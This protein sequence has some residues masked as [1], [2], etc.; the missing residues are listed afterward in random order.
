MAP[1]AS[2]QEVSGPKAGDNHAV[3]RQQVFMIE[4]WYRD[5]STDE[6][7]RL[8]DA[9]EITRA[10]FPWTANVSRFE[11]YNDRIMLE[12]PADRYDNKFWQPEGHRDSERCICEVKLDTAFATDILFDEQ[13]LTNPNNSTSTTQITLQLTLAHPPTVSPKCYLSDEEAA[14]D[15][16]LHES[17]L[18]LLESQAIKL[19]LGKWGSRAEAASGQVMLKMRRQEKG[20]QYHRQWQWPGVLHLL[21]GVDWQTTYNRRKNEALIKLRL[22]ELVAHSDYGPCFQA[23]GDMYKLA[24]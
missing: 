1:K 5:S 15:Q 16:P 12:Q 3:G 14:D 4:M 13:V 9:W 17:K 7:T 10:S 19:P 24:P 21:S 8:N 18:R 11:L 22:S 6:W 20:T 2:D 23:V